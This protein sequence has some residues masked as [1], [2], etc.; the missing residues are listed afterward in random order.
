MESLSIVTAKNA[1]AVPKR[2]LDVMEEGIEEEPVDNDAAENSEP[3]VEIVVPTTADEKDDWDGKPI[4]LLLPPE[5]MEWIKK[6]NQTYF[7]SYLNPKEKRRREKRWGDAIKDPNKHVTNDTLNGFTKYNE[8]REGPWM[9]FLIA[10]HPK[11]GTTTLVANLAK[12]APMKVKDFCTSKPSTLMH[13]LIDKWPQKFPDILEGP[14]KYIPDKSQWLVGSKCP[15][16]I[17]NPEFISRYTIAHPRLKLIVG[18]RHPILWFDSFMRM[19]NAANYYRRA[20]LCPHYANIDPVSG[21]PGGVSSERARFTAGFEQCINECRCGL[22]L[23]FHRSRLHLGLARV[24]KTELSPSEREL[25]APGDPDGGANLF[26]AQAVNPVFVYD[27]IQMK[28]DSYWDELAGF[29][30]ISHIPNEHYRGHHKDR[31]GTNSNATLCIPFY[32]ELRSRIMEHSYNM[33]IWLEDYFLPL[34]LDSSRPDVVV[35]NATSFKE[36]LKTYQTDPCGRLVRNDQNGKYLLDAQ[37]LVGTNSTTFEIHSTEVEA[38][39]GRFPDTDKMKQEHNAKQLAKAATAAEAAGD[40]SAATTSD[41]RAGRRRPKSNPETTDAEREKK[42]KREKRERRNAKRLRELRG[43][44]TEDEHRK[45]VEAAI[46]MAHEAKRQHEAAPEKA[47]A[48]A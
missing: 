13:Y 36:V 34:A 20:K 23:C 1:F 27:Q 21:F 11:T 42:A 38:C 7:D 12:V 48:A 18:L 35:A 2:W 43:D 30:G 39:P 32:D 40:S 31:T 46:A 37:Y 17:G 47:R 3:A 25:L 16:F 45:K 9:D 44:V 10:G 26:S 19:G 28:R 22:P 14:T 33:S 24:G 5:E 4:H 8:D 6:R 15:M 29:L 41:Q